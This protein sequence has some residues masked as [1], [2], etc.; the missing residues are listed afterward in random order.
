MNFQEEQREFE[1]ILAA[2]G[3]RELTD[4]ERERLW[5]L[6]EVDESRLHAFTDHC[7]LGA[8]LASLTDSQLSS[9]GIARQPANI[10]KL[11]GKPTGRG[12]R[13]RPVLVAAGIA[14]AVTLGILLTFWN[15]PE[16]NSS[17][18]TTATPP[19]SIE[20]PAIL[21][22]PGIS[23]DDRNDEAVALSGP[24]ALANS[25]T[26]RGGLPEGAASVP[27]KITFNRHVR[28]ILAENCFFCHGPDEKKQKAD[29]RLDSSAGASRDLG[30]YAAIVPGDP[31]KSEA[32][33]RIL[34]D[35]P[36]TV[37]PPPDSHRSLS[38]SDREIL[39]RWI[40]EGAVYEAHWAFVTPVRP[41]VPQPGNDAW[42]E[43]PVDA[44]ILSRL[45]AEGLE[46]NPPASPRALLRRL[47]LDLT[48]LPPIPAE[49]AAFENEFAR[50]PRSAIR[51]TVDRLL[52]SPHYGERMAL[53]WLDAARYSD[54][55]GFQQDGNRH[56][57][58]WRDWVIRAYQDNMPFDRFTIEQLAGDLLTDPTRDQLIATAFNRNHMLN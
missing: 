46:P 41:T 32:W 1:A 12:L 27:E 48:G 24:G 50:D 35:D 23:L 14:A 28:P 55:N 53:A 52:N 38:D 54:S 18:S 9:E 42:V 43:N 49:A 25:R 44:F 45:E 4:W 2:L 47:S 3:E 16:G 22:R 29:L 39:R 20:Q 15:R 51:D 34:S 21:R 13:L 7:F 33:R 5:E 26:P 40:E 19:V 57:W 10:V 30:G 17:I 37:M 31:E 36:D 58:P 11:P 8:D 56:Q 6:I